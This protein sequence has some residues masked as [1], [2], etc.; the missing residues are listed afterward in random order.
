MYQTNMSPETIVGT[1]DDLEKSE[2]TEDDCCHS[3]IDT[4]KDNVK[5]N[6]TPKYEKIYY[7][8]PS[9]EEGFMRKI[10]ENLLELKDFY[11]G[12][13]LYDA[14]KRLI[15]S[16][17]GIAGDSDSYG[18]GFRLY[19][20]RMA[21]SITL[22]GRKI[23]KECANWGTEQTGG[24]VTN[25][26]T[27]GVGITMG[28]EKSH[29]KVVNDALELEE[30][31][32]K[33]IREWCEKELCVENSTIKMEAEKLMDPVFVPT[34]GNGGMVKKKYGYLTVWEQ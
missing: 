2:Y 32:T 25:G 23:I 10:I 20:W 17:Y 30:D 31:M 12:T 13:D 4:R 28:S 8:K 26:D 21:E 14:V 34:N 11:D 22:Q 15:N 19:D 33:F 6:N 27:D 7:L 9:V 3:Y 16:V 24:V 5:K 29:A 18:K 1:K